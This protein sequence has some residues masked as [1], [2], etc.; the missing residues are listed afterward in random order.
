MKLVLKKPR[1]T[2][3]ILPQNS[4]QWRFVEQTLFE[5][6]FKYGF[7]EIRVP[8]FEHTDLFYWEVRMGA[9][10]TSVVSS[11][12]L[13]HHVT[14]PINNRKLLE[15]FLSFPHE[16][17]K[18]DQVHKWVMEYADKRVPEAEEEVKNLYFHSYRIWMEK[19]YYLYRT[20]FYKRLK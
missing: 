4:Y 20:L 1:G 17:R 12:N 14:M 16:L 19:L 9:W 18:S 2:Q 6:S 5:T 13:Y 15:I 8:T 11:Q 7:K 3:D 10:G